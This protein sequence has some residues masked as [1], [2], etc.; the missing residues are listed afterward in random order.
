M[1]G[2]GVVD[3]EFA[4]FDVGEAAEEGFE[5]NGELPDFDAGRDVIPSAGCLTIVSR[6]Q[7]HEACVALALSDSPGTP[8]GEGWE[9]LDSLSYR[10][11]YGGRLEVWGPT[12]GAASPA[13]SPMVVWGQ[14]VA[15]GEPVLELD[16]GR[17]YGVQ[18]WAQGRHDAAERFDAALRAGADALHQGLE[19]Y[20]I[21][22][23]PDGHQEAPRPRP[24][25]TRRER[26]VARHG[27]PPL[28]MRG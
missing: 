14:A 3:V 7:D 26:S 15:P 4:H 10:P 18:V 12:S 28:N 20:V 16:P 1:S 27:E 5:P 19:A 24:A 25:L 22:F 23:T 17:T 8:A 21:V 11:V 9:L 13:A 2:A 6:V